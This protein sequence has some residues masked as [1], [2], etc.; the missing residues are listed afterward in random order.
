MLLLLQ[1]NNLLAVAGEAPAP[2]PTVQTSSGGW[3]NW[4]D[5]FEH[6]RRRRAKKKREDEEAEEAL[7]D[8]VEHE[9]AQL[10]HKQIEK[11]NQ[12]KELQRIKELVKQY[13]KAT[14]TPSLRVQ[15]A[16]QEATIK[17]TLDSYEKVQKE[18]LRMMEEEEFAVI[19]AMAT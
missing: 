16:I 9:I 4:F 6:E 8:K 17:Q 1:L 5:T 12:R 3:S 2:T 7:A 13:A 14:D 10:M 15:K 19:L 18:F 11:D